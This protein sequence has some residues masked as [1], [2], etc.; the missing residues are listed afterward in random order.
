MA[1]G[2][3]RLLLGTVLA[4][5]VALAFF[6]TAP[7]LATQ[8]AE[9]ASTNVSG[10]VATPS[11]ITPL[12]I[13]TIKTTLVNNGASMERVGAVMLVRDAAGQTVLREKQ[14]GIS[15]AKQSD[16]AVYWEWRIP[17][18]LADGAYS[19]EML[20]VDESGRVLAAG[21]NAQAFQV[22]RAA[23]GPDAGG[24]DIP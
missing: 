8:A 24:R 19:V 17:S 2:G 6:L 4:G 20:I 9:R 18:R 16:L 14:T 11:S 13:L 3:T 1:P 10:T 21:T 22:V 12:D 23:S 15:L 5:M 7:G